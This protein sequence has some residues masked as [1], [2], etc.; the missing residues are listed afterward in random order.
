[1]GIVREQYIH[2]YRAI[3]APFPVVR[4][5]LGSDRPRLLTAPR[6]LHPREASWRRDPVLDLHVPGLRLAD[7]VEFVAEPAVDL[8]GPLPLVRRRLRWVPLDHREIHPVVEADLEA[9][10]IDDRRTMLSLLASYVPPMGRLGTAVD[11]VALHRVAE[12]ALERYFDALVAELRH[13][14]RGQPVT[15]DIT[16]PEAPS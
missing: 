15:P 8:P 9:E 2:L 7:E 10:P 3:G 12:A 13:L 16:V 1:M 5:L 11:R 4:T 14:A 6:R